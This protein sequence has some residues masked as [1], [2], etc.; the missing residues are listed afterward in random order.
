MAD[1][2]AGKKRVA[3]H[4]DETNL[5]ENEIIKA[6]LNTTKIDEPKTPYVHPMDHD[7]GERGAAGFKG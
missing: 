1:R 5:A 7:S 4:F 2:S 3:V 6:S